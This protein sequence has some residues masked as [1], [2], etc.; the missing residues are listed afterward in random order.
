MLKQLTDNL[1]DKF[2]LFPVEFIFQFN[3]FQGVLL[4]KLSHGHLSGISVRERYLRLIVILPAIQP[5][6]D[7]WGA[8]GFL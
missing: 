1:V 8:T 2:Y 3:S 5:C 6:K 4:E 7:D